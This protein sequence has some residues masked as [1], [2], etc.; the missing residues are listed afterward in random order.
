MAN[1]KKKFLNFN[2]F[3]LIPLIDGMDLYLSMSLVT[4]LAIFFFENLETSFSLILITFIVLI[5]FFIRFFT[6]LFVKSVNEKIQKINPIFLLCLSFFLP[7]ILPS[8]FLSISL[9]IFIFSRILVGISFSLLSLNYL[10][11]DLFKEDENF[12]L[13][14]LL[15]FIIG[16]ILGCFC[17]LII[18]DI[19]SNQELN[20]WAWKIV[21]FFLLILTLLLALFFKLK[22]YSSNLQNLDFTSSLSLKGIIKK[23]IQNL[24]VLIP[25]LAFIIFSSSKWLPKFS[26]PENMQFLEFNII[27]IVL[28]VMFSLFFYPLI[29]LIGKMRSKNFLIP[30]IILISILS[31][32][33][34]NSSS[35]SINLLKFFISLVASFC[36]CITYQTI[37]SLRDL[38]SI[39]IFRLQNIIYLSSSLLT[40]ILFYYF[41][42]FSISYNMVYLLVGSLFLITFVFEKYGKK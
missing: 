22:K 3:S 5:N 2:K 18:D 20:S 21:Y 6:P 12:F 34:E 29:N 28:I 37:R 10:N 11:S 4:F 17:F 31:F 24:F 26:N 13:K 30:S 23:F 14:Y 40:P 7:V 15:T 19:F 8:D 27:N 39:D 1:R 36:L 9:I 33:F 35:Y 42:N 32:F 25:F 16:L 38:T 41:I